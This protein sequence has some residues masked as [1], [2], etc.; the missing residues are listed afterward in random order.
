MK[1]SA[2][3]QRHALLT[4]LCLATHRVSGRHWSQSCSA[5][6]RGRSNTDRPSRAQCTYTCVWR[7]WA[8]SGK[9]NAFR[10][11]SSSSA[12]CVRE[13]TRIA[14]RPMAIA[15]CFTALYSPIWSRKCL[16]AA[17]S[18]ALGDTGQ[19]SISERRM[20]SRR[21]SPCSP[22]GVS[23]M[24]QCGLCS[25]NSSLPAVGVQ[26]A[27][28]GNI[29]GR[30]CSHSV[31]ER[32]GSK[33]ARTTR[34]LRPASQPAIFVASVDLPLPPF[35]F[36]TN[37]V[38]IALPLPR[39]QRPSCDIVVKRTAAAYVRRLGPAAAWT[40]ARTPAPVAAGARRQWPYPG[41]LQA[42]QHFQQRLDRGGA[43]SFAALATPAGR[44][45]G[46]VGVVLERH[47]QGQRQT[48]EGVADVLRRQ[49]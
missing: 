22:A 45:V 4:A 41:A 35:G 1:M 21:A 44:G 37:S 12:L 26:L 38:C 43:Q 27:I 31:D 10:N 5:R 46:P 13:S 33:S 19:S 24:S 25:R 39:R 16:V 3:R 23:R 9:S 32:S 42:R 34:C 17:M 28:A 49:G 15:P 8:T 20:A 6:E 36:A 14:T 30:R 11:S 18:K 7:K 40:A 29:A 2:M 48:T 47:L